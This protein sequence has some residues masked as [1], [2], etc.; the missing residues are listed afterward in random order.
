MIY[1]N[2]LGRILAEK[3]LIHRNVTGRV[4]EFRARKQ[5]IRAVCV[6]HG[7]KLCDASVWPLEGK[8]G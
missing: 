2:A 6:I 7:I 8:D 4:L 3:R 1:L 5:H